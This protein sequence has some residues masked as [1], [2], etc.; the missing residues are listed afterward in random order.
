MEWPYPTEWNETDSVDGDVLVLGGGI[1]GCWAAIGAAKRG[2]NVVLV[3]K[4]ATVSSG[5]GGSGCDHWESAATN[6]CSQ[7]T[8]EELTKALID[9]HGGYCNGI[10][11]FIECQEGYDR[12]LDLE[13]MGGKIRGYGRRVLGCR[14]PG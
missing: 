11:H 1:A 12:L 4:G 14:V 6:P 5:A 7:I 8:P 13:T 10:S 9:S 2:A 3:E